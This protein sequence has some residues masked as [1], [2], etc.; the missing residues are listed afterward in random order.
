MSAEQKFPASLKKRGC[1]FLSPNL[2]SVIT[3]QTKKQLR[4]QIILGQMRWFCLQ[5]RFP[6]HDQRKPLHI[7]FLVWQLVFLCQTQPATLKWPLAARGQGRAFTA[8]CTNE[9]QV[10]GPVNLHSPLSS[11]WS[12]GASCFPSAGKTPSIGGQT[13]APRLS[14]RLGDR[15]HLTVALQGFPS[16]SVFSSVWEGGYLVNLPEVNE[17]YFFWDLGEERARDTMYNNNLESSLR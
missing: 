2:V 17:S 4:L 5:I 9:C 15:M 1:V 6:A 11:L 13:A 14:Q 3:K 16:F 8:D 12:R 10:P 7:L